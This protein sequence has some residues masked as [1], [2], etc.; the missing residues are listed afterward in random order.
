[1]DTDRAAAHNRVWWDAIRRQRDAGLITKNHD[2]AAQI[3]AGT[4]GLCPEQ[5][6]FLGDVAGK[7]LL[8]LGCGDGCELVVLARLGAEATG[9]DNSPV[10]LAAAQRTADALGVRVRLVQADFLRLPEELLRGQFDR[11][12]SSHATAWI[13]DLEQWLGSVRRA[14]APGGVFVLRGGHSLAGFLAP[15]GERPDP[16]RS[17]YFEQGPFVQRVGWDAQWNPLGEEHTFVEWSH[18]LG[19]VVTAVARAGLRVTDLAEVAEEPVAA[20]PDAF[21]LRATNG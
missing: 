2:V 4:S 20:Y 3:L 9:V 21:V 17:S 15:R 8:D 1:V 10:Q 6:A 18:T 7:R 11:V 19:A 5:L 16:D 14:L 13:G 12:F